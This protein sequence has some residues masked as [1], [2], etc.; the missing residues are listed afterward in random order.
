MAQ[1]HGDTLIFS[2]PPVIAAHAAVGG[3]KES[4]S[5][6]AEGFDELSRDNRL[7]Q[8]TWEAAEKVLQ[9]RAARL[10]LQKAGAAERS[11]NLV[12]AGDLQAQCTASN[13]T[14]RE[15]DIPFAGVFGACSTMAEALGL[16]AA[17]CAGGMAEGILAMASGHFCAAERQ[18]RTPLS[19]GA[20]RTPT[21]QWTATAAG[22]C[23]LRPAGPGVLI[24]AATF[25]RVQD[26]RVRDINN[27][28][29]AMAP[30][31]AATLL[32]YLADTHTQPAAL[33]CIYTGDL[34]RVGSDLLAQLL[35]AE[36][37]GPYH[38]EDCG[39]LLYGSDPQVHSGGS[40]PGCCASVLSAHIL[41]RLESGEL[42][43]V[44]FIATGALMSQTTFLQKESIPAIAH[45]VELAAPA[46]AQEE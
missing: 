8:K 23:L 29:A 45:L 9:L 41:P 42:K 7:G 34:G 2:A 13:Y 21:S 4:R 14:M 22:C 11:V 5:P 25:G 12:L 16:G 26:Y 27:M 35:E 19:Y 36:G 20:V 46:A 6:L 39:C 33:D 24:R 44:V 30:A 31:A 43:R 38:H 40:G 18:F 32:H 10:C 28:G 1:R 17:L 37:I 3:K 15:L